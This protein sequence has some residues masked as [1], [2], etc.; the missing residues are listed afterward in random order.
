MKNIA[1]LTGG[2]AAEV[3]ISRRS[4]RTVVAHLPRDRYRPYLVELR[5]QQFVEVE[6]EQ[7]LD[8]N[9][10]GFD[11]PDGRVRF[12]AVY[13]SIHGDPYENGRL[14]GYFELLQLSYTGAGPTAMA[15]TFDKQS[16]KAAL[17]GQGIPMAASVRVNKGVPIDIHSITPLKFPCFVKPNAN[18]SSYGVSRVETAS[19]LTAAINKGF[20]YDDALLIEEF[21]AGRE[22]TQ[23]VY[24]DAEGQVVIL[25]ITEIRTSNAFFDYNAK[26]QGNSEEI[27]PANLSP[28]LAA[29]CS[30]QTRRI[31]EYLQLRGV[32]RVDYI[33]RGDQFFMLEVNTV[34]GMS[35]ASVIPQQC[36][37]A[38][39]PLGELLHAVLLDASGQ[40]VE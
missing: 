36:T 1:V 13:G 35:E 40:E 26:Y 22:F 10:F 6:T 16:T 28:D 27:T 19:E 34:P 29:T 37:A 25:P 3:E 12:A 30:A 31:Y 23:G 7:V 5:G 20:Q 9:D 11:G 24:R 2:R 14:Q 15:L 17:A 18:G 39:I 21:L 8:L 4:A 38:G 32:S 33:L